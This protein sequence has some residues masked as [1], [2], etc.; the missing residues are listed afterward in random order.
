[1][2]GM[3]VWPAID[4]YGGH[5]VRLR[6]GDLADKT[7]YG[8]DPLDTAKSF[9]DS[10]SRHLH[11]VDLEGA[12][13]GSPKHLGTLRRISN[14]LD[15]S[16]HF[17]GGLRES[18]QIKSALDSGAD[19]AMIGSILFR[20]KE[21]PEILYG[22]FGDALLPS[23]DVK[24]QSVAISA[25]RESTGTSPASVLDELIKVGYSNFLVTSADRDGTLAGP[26][27]DLYRELVRDGVTIIAAGGVGSED[28]L[29]ALARA[30]AGGAVL[31]KALYE[32]RADLELA[33]QRIRDL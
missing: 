4:L 26:D 12:E 24:G 1:M 20:S 5:V 28:D 23:V 25:W 13:H 8:D 2:S 3:I 27:L 32:G 21:M 17:G 7:V 33:I 9:Y 18:D 6:K 15:I 16:I 29:V 14:E 19:R 10:G 22:E 30:G 11:I 31:G